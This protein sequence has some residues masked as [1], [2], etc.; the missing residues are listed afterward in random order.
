[1]LQRGGGGGEAEKRGGCHTL[2]LLQYYHT[3]AECVG[4]QGDSWLIEFN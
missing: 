1:L 3:A 4:A 2:S